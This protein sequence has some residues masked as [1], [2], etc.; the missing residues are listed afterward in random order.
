MA[1]KQEYDRDSARWYV[2]HDTQERYAGVTSILNVLNKE[3]INK[4]KLKLQ[5]TYLADNR[6]RLAEGTKAQFLAEAKNDAVWLD[7]WRV[8]REVGTAAHQVLDN[9]L[10]NN[11][12]DANVKTV[13]GWEGQSPLLWVPRWW[14]ELNERFDV[15]PLLN[16]TMVFSK[17]YGYA[18]T[19]D[20]AWEI[21]G[22]LCMVD[23]KTNKNGP[24]SSVAL[25]N[26][27]YAMAEE[28]YD[29]QGN[30]QPNLTFAK[31]RVFWMRPEGWNLY[32]LRFDEELWVDFR[33]LVRAYKHVKI[34]ESGAVEEALVDDGLT[35]KRWF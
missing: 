15:K 4:A 1:L 8:A 16:E 7:D 25:Q 13:D 20:N 14:E 27:A 26:V 33:A 17:K 34:R 6:K 24:R 5:A 22:Q 12:L 23:A 35:F 32:E 9:I 30:A 29:A 11:N 2:N 28:Y 31:S 10:H 21:D 18:G 19:F 3:G